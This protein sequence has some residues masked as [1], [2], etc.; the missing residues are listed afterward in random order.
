MQYKT[1][2]KHNLKFD[3]FSSLHFILTVKE[4]IEKMKK[5]VT[6]SYGFTQYLIKV[7]KIKHYLII[8]L[9]A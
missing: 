4:N 5:N 2:N 7:R 9:V 3:F 8:L 6:P 1:D